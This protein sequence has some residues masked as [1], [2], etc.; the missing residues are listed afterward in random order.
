[1]RPVTA[2]ARIEAFAF[3]NGQRLA[4][5]VNVSNAQATERHDAGAHGS[6]GP[7]RLAKS[8][9]PRRSASL[10]RCS[11]LTR[12]LRRNRSSVVATSSSRVRVVLIIKT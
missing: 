10:T 2:I 12:R 9:R 8:L 11:R 7:R 1:M 3:G 4:T 6:R 5:V